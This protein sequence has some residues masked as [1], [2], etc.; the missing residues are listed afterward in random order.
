MSIMSIRFWHRTT[1]A[2]TLVAFGSSE[3]SMGN[4]S[5]S[6]YEDAF[7]REHESLSKPGDDFMVCG[8]SL[9]KKSPCVCGQPIR[10]VR[11]SR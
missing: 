2:L 9:D 11:Y 10:R 3:T 8:G 7:D 5:A 6:G 4:M 1:N